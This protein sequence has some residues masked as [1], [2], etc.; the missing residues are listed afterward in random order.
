MAQALPPGVGICQCAAKFAKRAGWDL[1]RDSGFLS[2][3]QEPC[4]PPA[5]RRLVLPA[6]GAAPYD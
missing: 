5:R 3:N 2:F 1:L 4:A 6:Q